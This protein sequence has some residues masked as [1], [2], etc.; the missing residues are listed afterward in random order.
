MRLTS[1]TDFKM[2]GAIRSKSDMQDLARLKSAENSLKTRSSL[3]QETLDKQKDFHK[4]KEEADKRIKEI[5]QEFTSIINTNFLKEKIIK[6]FNEIG[7]DKT[8]E[9]YADD[10]FENIKD[11]DLK[12][13]IIKSFKQEGVEKTLEKY[14][15]V[16]FGNDNSNNFVQTVIKSFNEIGIDETLEN[17]AD[18]LQELQEL[19]IERSEL[20]NTIFSRK[21]PLYE[22]LLIEIAGNYADFIPYLPSK[23]FAATMGRVLSLDKLNEQQIDELALRLEQDGI[24]KE[25]TFRKYHLKYFPTHIHE[26]KTV[27]DVSTA[28]RFN[29]AVF[30]NINPHSS[31]RYDL[32]HNINMLSAL[33]KSVPQILLYATSEEIEFLATENSAGMGKAILNCP[34]ILSVLPAGFFKKHRVKYFFSNVTKADFKTE[35]I[36]YINENNLS[37][38]FPELIEY[39]DDKRMAKKSDEA[40]TKFS[41]AE[42][43]A[44]AKLD[45]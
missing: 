4:N 13:K 20:Q 8:L 36:D 26:L 12:E 18:I 37:Q 42:T 38:K 44:V 1:D 35:I 3:S 7:I 27:A 39:F 32:T 28:L 6:S 33:V 2:S 21:F 15:D 11:N 24:F 22:T 45:E 40:Q 25:P 31:F 30:Q 19:S 9:M 29:P 16:L 10:L 43:S 5:D 17:F 41:K 23:C 34:Q 14:A